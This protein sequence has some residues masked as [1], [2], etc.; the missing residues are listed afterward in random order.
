MF[1]VGAAETDEGEGHVVLEEARDGVAGVGG[2]GVD[3]VVDEAVAG[4][5]LQDVPGAGK[6]EAMEE[7]VDVVGCRWFVGGGRIA[8]GGDGDGVEVL[9]EGVEGG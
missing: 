4:V 6:G 8:H 5:E 1:G 2:G 3:E 7:G 9:V